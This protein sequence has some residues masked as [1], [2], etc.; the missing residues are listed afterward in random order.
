MICTNGRLG[1]IAGSAANLFGITRDQ[2]TYQSM[3]M[4][5]GNALM[6]NMAPATA[7]GATIVLRRRFSASGFLDDVRTHGATYFNY[8]GRSLAY[9]LATAPTPQDRDNRL[10][11]GFGTEASAR[12]T[13]EFTER[14]GCAIEESYGSSEGTISISAGPGCPPGALGLPA[15][16]QEV[17]ILDRD[18]QLCPPARRDAAG[19]LLNADEAI[20]EIVNLRGAAAFEGY[21]RN[22][23][24]EQARL[25][26]DVYRSGDL[27]F[28]D[29]DGWFYC[30]GRD[31]DWLRVDSENFA[32]APVEAV[33]DRFP[34]VVVAAVYAVPDARTGDSVMAALQ[35]TESFDP[36]AFSA[37]LRA[38]P[39]LGT[40]WAPKYVRIIEA[41][42]VTGTNKI[43]KQS[44]R[45]QRWEA[46]SV[47]I[48]IGDHDYRAMTDDDRTALSTE[49]TEHNRSHLLL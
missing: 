19:R 47:W 15:P 41:M 8:V 4:F 13:V 40:K 38:S 3:P 7:A 22:P 37:F 27:G 42:P 34:P 18:G 35:V 43:A 31:T 11:L 2:V 36:T 33:L 5:H 30:A 24:A 16:G 32:A 39:D 14:F 6:S 17:A 44:L 29:E 25:D 46:P 23:E 10:R 26:G 20:G 21:Y 28:R 48:R 45:T 49:F 12:D 9:I 1:L